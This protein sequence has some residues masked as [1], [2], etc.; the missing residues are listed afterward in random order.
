MF[1]GGEFLLRTFYMQPDIRSR[2]LRKTWKAQDL[3]CVIYLPMDGYNVVTAGKEDRPHTMSA[4][5]AIQ[6]IHVLASTVTHKISKSLSFSMLKAVVIIYFMYSISY[7]DDETNTEF[8]LF[9]VF[10]KMTDFLGSRAN[11]LV[12]TV[13]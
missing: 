13:D 8:T 5:M 2:S 11:I 6:Y 9:N 3:K 10:Q 12:I 1:T 7:R 4:I